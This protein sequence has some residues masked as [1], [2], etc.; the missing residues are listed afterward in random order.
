MKMEDLK[1]MPNFHHTTL[2]LSS[3]MHL[4]FVRGLSSMRP[5]SWPLRRH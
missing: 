1:F 3:F 2:C 5:Q 4:F